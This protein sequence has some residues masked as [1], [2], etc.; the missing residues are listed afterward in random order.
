MSK[1][2][3]HGDWLLASVEGVSVVEYWQEGGLGMPRSMVLG[4]VAQFGFRRF[5]RTVG[6][7]AGLVALMVWPAAGAA[8]S[9]SA[10]T[11]SASQNP[12]GPAGNL[13]AVSCVNVDSCEAVGSTLNG[14]GKQVPLAEGWDGSVWAVQ[15]LPKV[16]GSKVQLASVACGG[17]GACEATGS[18]NTKGGTLKPLAFGWNGTSWSLQAPAGLGEFYS[19]ACSGPDACE[20][21][22]DV[23]NPGPE[24]NDSLAEF[25]DGSSWTVQMTPQSGSYSNTLYGVSCSAANACEAVGQIDSPAVQPLAE[26]WSGTG[27]SL[28]SVSL[29]SGATSGLLNNLSCVASGWC[30]AMGGGNGGPL[31]ESWDGTQWSI[32]PAP[33]AGGESSEFVS[34]SC[35]SSS[36]CQA[37]GDDFVEHVGTAALA[38]SWDGS[39][40]STES[41]VDP[42][43]S[44]GTLLQGVACLTTGP[45][46]T[47]GQFG[48]YGY[49]LALAEGWDT[50]N[51]SLQSTSDPAKAQAASELL[52]GSCD[53]S[54]ACEAVGIADGE[55]LIESWSGS[56]WQTQAVSL[57]ADA[58]TLVSLSGVSCD[59][60]GMCEAV[61]SYYSNSGAEVPLAEFYDGTSWTAQTPPVPSGAVSGALSSVSC[62]PSVDACEAVGDYTISSG[63]STQQ[64]TLAE[65]W[66]GTSWTVQ[67]T[68][69][70]SGAAQAWLAGISCAGTPGCEA[71]G[72]YVNGTGN[73]QALRE[74]WDGTTWT[75]QSA[76]PKT[77]A[78]HGQLF[79]VS[80]AT[81]SSCE[82][83]GDSFNT[84]GTPVT[85]AEAWNGTAWKNQKPI[86]TSSSYANALMAVSCTASNDCEAIGY[87]DATT[88]HQSPVTLAEVWNGAAWATQ[89]TPN[90]SDGTFMT[91]NGITCQV[92]TGCKAVGQYTPT[93][94]TPERT[95]ALAN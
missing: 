7:P 90:P 67:A 57:P 85:Y 8:A 36:A 2:K 14:K 55:P 56:S 79:G 40:W 12:K 80:C 94:N 52:S 77:A 59:S 50:T 60:S 66:D 62:N 41:P 78:T 49:P 31:A 27:W 72:S 87:S 6:L 11:L 81:A 83:V 65:A 10:W 58:A 21:V 16:S 46:E 30:M 84:N 5:L 24:L 34:I 39:G 74:G 45:C 44:R 23:Y 69:N 38:D 73:D 53:S 3:H 91:L 25:W 48:V 20:A 88:N 18:F 1:T 22:G 95:L 76:P 70:P 33:V 32:Q 28:Q 93:G 19:V 51:W 15:S 64:L 43:G 26:G 89:S 37:V 54:G 63:G 61:G 17:V 82:A 42:P 4:R 47:V 86:Q 29:P 75:I 9:G 35:E 71:V 92:T 13:L 68:P